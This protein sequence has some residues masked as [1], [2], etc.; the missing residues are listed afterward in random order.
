MRN[1]FLALII[2]A[3]ICVALEDYY[4][5]GVETDVINISVNVWGEV[6]SP[7]VHMI[8]WD[9]DLTSALSAAGGPSSQADLSSVRIIAAGIEIEYNL[10][11]FLNGRGAPVPV[12]EPN[13]T[14][15]VGRSDYEWWKDVVDFGYK[16]LIMANV[17]WVMSR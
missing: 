8:P 3:S 14:V 13:A 12:M 15:Y 17:I 9:S 5:P 11:D 1:Y 7:G 4:L 16:I 10:S 2:F 6:I